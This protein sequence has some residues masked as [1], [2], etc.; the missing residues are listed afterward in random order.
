MKNQHAKNVDKKK[1]NTEEDFV[2]HAT[3]DKIPKANTIKKCKGTCLIFSRV[4]GFYVPV[5]R[6]NKGK[7]EEVK[8]RVMYN[9]FD[10]KRKG[11]KNGE[12]ICGRKV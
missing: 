5:D 2:G 4:T 9:A 7:V 1:S 12:N 11:D 3:K 6:M 8:D 10:S